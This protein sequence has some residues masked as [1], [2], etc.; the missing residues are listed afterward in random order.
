[1]VR[2]SKDIRL[3][4]SVQLKFIMKLQVYPYTHTLTPTSKLGFAQLYQHNF[5]HKFT[6]ESGIMPH[7]RYTVFELIIFIIP[8]QPILVI[9]TEC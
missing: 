1:M 5:E 7:N 9:Q 8:T 2:M 3:Q 6:K 4:V